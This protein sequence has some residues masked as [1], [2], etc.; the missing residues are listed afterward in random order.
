MTRVQRTERSRRRSIGG[1]N[2]D[3]ARRFL[4]SRNMIIGPSADR[5]GTRGMADERS[6]ADEGLESADCSRVVTTVQA[7]NLRANWRV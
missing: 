3:R 2:S 5:M 6:S 4:G 7:V 1:R